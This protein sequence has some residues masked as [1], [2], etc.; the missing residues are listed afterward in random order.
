MKKRFF[1]LVCTLALALPLLP[2][3]ARAFETES[4]WIPASQAPADA[5]IV[6][7]S[8]EITENVYSSNTD[9]MSN[10]E[11]V[12]LLGIVWEEPREK[13]YKVASFPA[14]FKRD[15]GS[16]NDPGYYK[17]GNWTDYKEEKFTESAG[18]LTAV[19]QPY[20][21]G[22]ERQTVE[23]VSTGFVYWHWTYSVNSVGRNR[24]IY[25]QNGWGP[26]NRYGYYR[27]CAFSSTRGDY[28]SRTD[29]CEGL[30]MRNY[31]I[32]ERNTVD[33][34]QGI[35][36]WFRFD[37]KEYK[38]TTE[39]KVLCYR[40]T[41][42]TGPEDVKYSGVNYDDKPEKWIQDYKDRY[43]YNEFMKTKMVKYKIYLPDVESPY[44]NFA[45][46]SYLSKNDTITVRCGTPDVTIL[47]TISAEG[48]EP[49]PERDVYP[50]NGIPVPKDAEYQDFVLAVRAIRDGWADS[51]TVFYDYHTNKNELLPTVMTL[52][53]ESVT[54]TTAVLRAEF[55]SPSAVD[56]V[57]FCYYERGNERQRQYVSVRSPDGTAASAPIEG[58]LPGTEYWVI[59]S[60]ENEEGKGSGNIV[61]FTTGGKRSTIPTDVK[62]SPS[63][64]ILQEGGTRT[65]LPLLSPRAA[66]SA[67]L[68]RSTDETVATVDENG[69]VTGLSSGECKIIADAV[70][71]RASGECRVE[72]VPTLLDLPEAAEFNFSENHMLGAC[73]ELNAVNGNDGGYREGGNSMKA[74]AYLARWSGPV[75]E[76]NA[77]Y[78][79]SN[80]V[81]FDSGLQEDLHVQ[82]V[83]F[84]PWR[85]NG[86]DNDRIKYSVMTYGAVYA[87]M[88]KNEE[89]YATYNCTNFYLPADRIKKSTS[90]HAVAIVG[91]DDNYPKENF[92]DSSTGKGLLPPGD[93][94]FICKSS[95]G[96]GMGEDGYIYV[97][98]YD[99]GLGTSLSGD[100]NAVFYLTETAENYN[101][102][103]QYDD[104]GATAKY[105]YSG[106][107][108]W[109]AN[110]FPRSGLEADELLRAVSFYTETP[111]VILD[112]YVVPDYQ[113]PISLSQLGGCL[114]EENIAISDAG[115]HT[116][117]L[118]EP[119]QLRKGDRFAV[120]LKEHRA[121]SQVSIYT[122]SRIAGTS[123]KAF[124]YA[125]ESFVSEDGMT[126]TDLTT[127]R[128]YGQSNV[129]LKAFTDS[130]EEEMPQQKTDPELFSA[131]GP[132]G[133]EDTLTAGQHWDPEYAA[134]MI[135]EGDG[136]EGGEFSGL[137][138]PLVLPSFDDFDDGY[139]YANNY[140]A[141]YDLRTQ[142]NGLVTPVRNQ[143]SISACWS[144]AAYASLESSLLVARSKESYALAGGMSS[145]GADDITIMLTAGDREAAV[146]VGAALQL[147]TEFYPY[148]SDTDLVWES[149]DPSIATVSANGTVTGIRAGVTSIHVSTEDGHSGAACKVEVLEPAEPVSVSLSCGKQMLQPGET[150]LMNY[151]VFPLNASVSRFTWTSDRP[152]IA[153][154][155]EN[156]VLTALR[157]GTATITVTLPGGVSAGCTVNVYDGSGPFLGVGSNELVTDGE[158]IRGNLRLI[159]RNPGPARRASVALAVYSGEGKLLKVVIREMTIEAGD[160]L[161]SFDASE[162][163]EQGA[164]WVRVFALADRA[165]ITPEVNCQIR[166]VALHDPE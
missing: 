103:Y 31:I 49:D 12:E 27:F 35:M 128:N 118:K 146:C 32:P 2:L 149:D 55:S 71:G 113:G 114:V 58:L 117:V 11:G 42:V 93:G 48:R 82:E 41:R 152:N 153:A 30:G 10:G 96:T 97:S 24:A 77:P 3:P 166:S 126:W 38:V 130:V 158:T 81:E 20:E 125:G 60:V 67:I 36:S 116:R 9:L 4:E 123:S 56:R 122:E 141:S 138:P 14:G 66:K 17:V 98:Y 29:Y 44:A 89:Q 119:I 155:D 164:A 111:G 78:P 151:Q 86:E 131:S 47:Y 88:R 110:V 74:T 50:A 154:V 63:F 147:Q 79:T 21:D 85:K 92:Y 144:F 16:F 159:T 91:W 129:C 26:H 150:A 34:C 39:K 163:S 28:E 134:W 157:L 53:P 106:N 23:Q 25:N 62:L 65:L 115:Y 43:N 64:I 135:A 156:G 90:L 73:S 124:A 6:D 140:P 1:S 33:S 8:W 84:L 120:I 5:E 52:A 68:W 104:F 136:E 59:S 94:A 46:G 162:L 76:E 45:A 19:P 95:W 83:L 13:F 165:P 70:I 99:G 108:G 137:V 142:E 69:V 7:T 107:T 18:W 101:K 148:G 57:R 72:V 40:S 105:Q 112:L 145:S 87:A 61:S 22:S 15:F 54:E 127:V 139:S 132:N 133:A 100:Q 121:K 143:G 102:I 80:F 160:A 37:Y 75:L 51:P 109:Y 161:M